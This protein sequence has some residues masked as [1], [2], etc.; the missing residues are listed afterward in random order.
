MPKSSLNGNRNTAAVQHWRRTQHLAHW[1]GILLGGVKL[2]GV[3]VD[4]ALIANADDLLIASRLEAANAFVRR[5]LPISLVHVDAHLLQLRKARYLDAPAP[6]VLL[7]NRTIH[8]IPV[9]FCS[10]LTNLSI[11]FQ[12]SNFPKNSI[13]HFI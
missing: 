2:E 3:V 4:T 5:R 7:P 9:L 13:N 11:T 12:G 8:I 10:P 6:L 1:L